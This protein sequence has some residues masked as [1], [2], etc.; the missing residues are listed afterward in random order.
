[1]SWVAVGVA[2][3]QLISGAQQA[4]TVRE[5]ARL[6]RD[7]DNMNAEYAK[8]DAYNA[9]QAGYSAEARYDSTINQTISGQKVGLASQGVDVNFGTAAEIQ[10][11][12]KLVG[13]L[14]K[15]DIR[16]QAHE[17]ALGYENQSSNFRLRGATAEAQGEYNAGAIKN[18]AL[19]NAAGTA[20]SGYRRGP[21]S[22]K[23]S[24]P[25]GSFVGS[26]KSSG[27]Y[28]ENYLSGGSKQSDGYYG[29]LTGGKYKF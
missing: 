10:V 4:E 13:F 14:N 21:P 2:G 9:E 22:A 7:L 23:T 15:L 27:F 16:N 24:A 25:E 5:N 3:F 6:Q 29:N 26:G 28:G 20:L 1:M 17:R 12:T 19:M 8:L 11:D 18:A